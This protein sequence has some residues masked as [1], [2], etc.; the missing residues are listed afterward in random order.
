[1][2]KRFN[3]RLVV[4]IVYLKNVT[5]ESFM[6]L[7]QIDDAT[8]YHVADL[9]DNRSQEEITDKMIKGWFRFFGLPDEMLLDSEGAMKSFSFESLMAQGGIRVRF[10]PA[11]A[12]WQLGKAERH[13][14]A[15]RWITK[16][17]ISQFGV[18]TVSDME[19]VASM[20]LHAKNTLTR[21]SGSSPAQWVFGRNHKL[22]VALLSEPES[23]EAKQLVSN[24]SKL[25]RIE[26]IRYAAMH[27]HLS[28]ENNQSLA[29]AMMRKGRPWRGP[30]EVGQRIAYWR[31]KNAY[32]NEGNEEGYRQGNRRCGSW[33]YWF[34]LR[35]Q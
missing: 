8:V 23:I 29:S 21:R 35:A 7:S 28:F 16:R 18:V 13:G 26:S 6:F 24:S 25:Q 15:F 20:A 5:G 11:D 19:L 32:D 22:P 27:E 4:D 9:L 1:M 10:V 12:H 34:R 17:L 14:H 31:F 30:L 2:A 33:S 3:D